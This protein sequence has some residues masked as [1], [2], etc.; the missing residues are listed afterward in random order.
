M[1]LMYEKISYRHFSV[2]E[3]LLTALEIKFQTVSSNVLLTDLFSTEHTVDEFSWIYENKL[4]AILKSDSTSI[5]IVPS[6][7]WIGNGQY[8]FSKIYYPEDQFQLHNLAKHFDEFLTGINEL[9]GILRVNFFGLSNI[10]ILD[11]KD[12]V[13]VIKGYHTFVASLNCTNSAIF[14]IKDSEFKINEQKQFFYDVNANHSAKNLEEN[15]W[16]LITIDIDDKYIDV[17]NQQID[18]Q[19]VIDRSA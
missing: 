4:K 1:D 10:A 9:P 2:L 15:W 12:D 16:Y 13:G 5:S 11:H 7:W 6:T 8:F 17:K 14:K 19:Q 3:K 18:C